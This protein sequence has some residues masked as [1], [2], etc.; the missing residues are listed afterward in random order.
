ME[1]EDVKK[2]AKDIHCQYLRYDKDGRLSLWAQTYRRHVKLPLF[3]DVERALKK[4]LALRAS[5]A[6]FLARKDDEQDVRDLY[7]RALLSEEALR[8]LIEYDML[9]IVRK[10]TSPT[11]IPDNAPLI[12]L[13]T[14]DATVHASPHDLGQMSAVQNDVQDD[15]GPKRRR[16]NKHLYANRPNDDVSLGFENNSGDTG[17]GVP[18]PF[19]NEASETMAPTVSDNAS[20]TRQA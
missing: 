20:P 7:D 18:G 6:Q 8:S 9:N 1:N 13:T 2:L 14:D 3:R 16:R 17:L 5:L 19:R 10:I 11:R 15:Y 12:D 4:G